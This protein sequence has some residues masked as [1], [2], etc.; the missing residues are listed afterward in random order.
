MEG[1]AFGGLA[2]FCEIAFSFG[3]RFAARKQRRRGNAARHR[4]VPPVRQED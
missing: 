4:G 3:A 1:L 2:T